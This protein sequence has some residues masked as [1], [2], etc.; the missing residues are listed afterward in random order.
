[1]WK[2]IYPALVEAGH[3]V[4]MYDR[5]GYGRSDPGP[6]FDRFYLDDRFLRESVEE[7][8]ILC[9]RLGLENINIVGQCEGGI[10]GLIYAAR[11]RDR[12][13]AAVVASALCH[14]HTT[15]REFNRQKF[16]LAFQE[17]DPGMREK[18]L[19]WHGPD[20]AEQLYEMART[21]GGAYGSDYFDIRPVLPALTCPTLVLYPDRSALFEVEQAVAFYR[22]LTRAELAVI[23]RCGHNTYEQKP[24]DYIRNILDFFD[25]AQRSGDIRKEDFSQTCASSTVRNP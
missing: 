25:R 15:M 5:R 16:P 17:L 12:V 18:L 4:V 22:G 10:I 20:R 23:P 11:F 6:D 21:R 1:M 8:A 24:R 9:E 7:M 2:N 3:R 14:S 13:R 19:E